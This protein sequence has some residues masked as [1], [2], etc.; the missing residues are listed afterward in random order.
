MNLLKPE[1]LPPALSQGVIFQNLVA[2][3][4]LFYQVNSASSFFVV[5]TGRFKLVHYTQSGKM[6][7]LQVVRAGESLAESALFSTV[8]PYTAIAKVAS[9]VIFYPKQL[10]L[11]SLCLYPDLAENFMTILVRHIHSLRVRLEWR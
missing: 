3:Q 9:R 10:L 11:S 8:Y 6:V 7:T 2:E 4:K 5:E 1:S